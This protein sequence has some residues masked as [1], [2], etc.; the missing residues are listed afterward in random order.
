LNQVTHGLATSTP[1]S[2]AIFMHSRFCA[3]AVRNIA[4]LLTDPCSWDCTRKA[5]SF[6]REGSSAGRFR[7]Q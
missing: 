4:E 5:P 7:W 2:L 3:A 6:L 1:I